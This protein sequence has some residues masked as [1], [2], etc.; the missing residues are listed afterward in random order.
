[1]LLSE[2]KT[3]EP[4]RGVF[5]IRNHSD[6]RV[7][8]RLERLSCGCSEFLSLELGKSLNP[9]AE[10]SAEPNAT[11]SVALTLQP[12]PRPILQSHSA[13]ISYVVPRGEHSDIELRLKL[14]VLAD[15]EV[16]PP[17]LATTFASGSIEPVQKRL[18]CTFQTRG[19]PSRVLAPRFENVPPR[20]MLINTR[21]LGTA[22][23][24][25]DIWS[26]TW[27]A[28]FRLVP[29]GPTHSDQSSQ[30]TASMLVQYDGKNDVVV[31]ITLTTRDGIQHIP[32]E[33]NFGVV[34][35]GKACRRK[36]LLSSLDATPFAV[37]AV[38]S[39]SPSVCVDN[40]ETLSASSA[41]HFLEVV[42]SA[43]DA[44]AKSG[45]IVV[46][47]TH[48]QCERLRIPFTYTAQE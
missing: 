25:N 43:L 35:A 33:I 42:C 10:F 18:T 17:V 8:M 46:E 45:S 38:G 12:T 6:S 28:F 19:K 37:R 36:V 31:P 22:S 14:Q 21:H 34:S 15:V 39:T 23:V 2:V 26:D 20:V 47:T 24:V 11:H 41:R 4:V 27:E 1:M 7:V 44:G 3:S 30:F 48:P 29:P 5:A 13:R 32:A 40:Q 9:N 16:S